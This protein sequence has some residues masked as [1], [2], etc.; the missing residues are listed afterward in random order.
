[1]IQDHAL[2]CV[3]NQVLVTWIEDQDA[4]GGVAVNATSSLGHTASCSSSGNSSCTLDDLLCG[5]TY[6]VQAFAQGALCW[7]KASSAFQIATGVTQALL[8]TYY[9]VLPK[10]L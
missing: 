4:T 10:F 1:M 8:Y 5:H 9:K 7:S 3:S 6:T 2:D